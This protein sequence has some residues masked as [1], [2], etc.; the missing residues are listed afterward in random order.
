M[1]TKY[2]AQYLKSN[3]DNTVKVRHEDFEG[4]D[5]I[6]V[7][8]IAAQEGV[9]NGLFYPA[10]E[11]RDWVPTWNGVPIPIKHPEVNGTPVSAK[12][13][14]IQ[15][16]TSVGF[17]FNV[18]FTND[19]KLKGEM[20]LNTVKIIKLNAGYIIDRF[21][22]NEIMEVSTGLYSN[23]EMIP[24]DY[25]GTPYTGIVRHIRPDH[26]AL[27]P[28]DIGACSVEDGCGAMRNNCECQE[29]KTVLNEL[30]KA[31]RLIGDSLG[32][33]H[34]K[35]NYVNTEVESSE[36]VD[37][38]EVVRKTTYEPVL[39]DNI[40][41]DNGESTMKV[42][43]DDTKVEPTEEVAETAETTETTETP[44]E[45]KTEAVPETEA[46]PE[47]D[48]TVEQ[49]VNTLLAKLKDNGVKEFLSNAVNEQS[50]KQTELIKSIVK[51]S[52]FTAEDLKGMTTNQIE[53]LTETLIKPDFSG[54]GAALKGNT[55]E[56]VPKS[57]F[58]EKESK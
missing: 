17:L 51:N 41:S 50:A 54:R 22:N 48:D 47:S 37:T 4:V 49:K 46:T 38:Q 52:K 35:E 28:N 7:P 1:K 45:T 34:S 33:K 39:S 3:V 30:S 21:E 29:Q 24:G 55:E 15:E 16:L 57:M 10:E 58:A 23:V 6:V 25:K 27:L 9:M 26:L 5:H 8:V 14:R 43:D 19:N 32:L 12:E 20:W 2:K 44:E 53:K 56:Y 18:E 11:F 36:A 40:E 42:N 31:M 13:P